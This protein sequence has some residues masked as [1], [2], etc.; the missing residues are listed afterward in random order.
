MRKPAFLQYAA[1]AAI[2]LYIVNFFML[3]SIGAQAKSSVI[4][5]IEL[6]MLL[7]GPCAVGIQLAA[8]VAYRRGRF[9]LGRILLE[10][11]VLVGLWW[12]LFESYR[13]GVVEI[14]RVRMLA[15]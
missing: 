7:I 2:A 6:A 5:N 11:V 1:S 8:L 9:P 13:A 10:S 4:M 15:G 14:E 3:A 12:M